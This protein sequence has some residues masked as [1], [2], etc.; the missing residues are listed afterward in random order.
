MKVKI[1]IFYLIVLNIYPNINYAEEYLAPS[2]W[3]NEHLIKNFLIIHINKI[4]TELSA[5]SNKK[6]Q[7]PINK[8]LR[9]RPVLATQPALI[10]IYA[11]SGMPIAASG[12]PIIAVPPVL[13]SAPV[14]IESVSYVPLSK[15]DNK[16][17]ISFQSDQVTLQYKDLS[18]QMDILS[19]NLREKFG[20]IS[21]EISG[22]LLKIIAE[23][24]QIYL[25]DNK[26][27][28]KQHSY[29]F[30]LSQ[31]TTQ[32]SLI[33]KVILDFLKSSILEKQS[34]WF[35]LNSSIKHSV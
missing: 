32:D 28:N 22:K 4:I 34:G 14:N 10:T 30:Y 5:I 24:E 6:S 27:Y 29:K 20:N 3:M 16:D 33:A 31:I 21:Q 23:L 15:R 26:I 35:H 9:R 25:Y 19:R 8:P 13:K 18:A 12:G 2:S 17:K 7:V 1:I 11:N